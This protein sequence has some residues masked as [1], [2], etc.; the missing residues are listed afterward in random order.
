MVRTRTDRHILWPSYFDS[1]RSRAE[2]RRVPKA[3]AVQEPTSLEIFE[4]AKGLGF[5]T[6]HQE[7]KSYPGN[8][9]AHEGCVSV[10]KSM[11]KTE[12]IEKVAQKLKALRQKA[13]A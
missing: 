11:K 5:G 10:E 9:W 6:T 8:W 1:G 3:L 13:Q 2:G 12:L 7:G 4:I